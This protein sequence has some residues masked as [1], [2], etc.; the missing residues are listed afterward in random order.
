M[1]DQRTVVVQ[2]DERGVVREVKTLGAED[3][4]PVAMVARETPS[5][6]N[7]RTLLQALFGNVGRIG[8][9]AAQA[10]TGPG[11]MAPGPGQIR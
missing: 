10:G 9:G 1:S 3:G 4:Q 7:E 6:G 8:P 5:P 2:F 11:T